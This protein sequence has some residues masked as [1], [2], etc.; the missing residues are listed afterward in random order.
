[1]SLWE[2]IAQ[3]VGKDLDAKV[4]DAAGV[5]EQRYAALS[6]DRLVF[7]HASV[8]NAQTATIELRGPLGS[9]RLASSDAPVSLGLG[10]E[11][12]GQTATIHAHIDGAVDPGALVVL[13]VEVFSS[14]DGAPSNE[15]S[16]N[17]SYSVESRL[18]DAHT[19]ELELRLQL[20]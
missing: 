2:R 17:Q 13:R 7:V 3:V 11:L 16:G 14:A 12:R 4:D 18:G 10:Q 8:T 15:H 1:M 6:D 20:G 9:R 19:S 5:A